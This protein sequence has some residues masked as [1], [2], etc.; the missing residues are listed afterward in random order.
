MQG[1][2]S[3]MYFRYLPFSNQ[4]QC[5]YVLDVVAII[6]EDE[7]MAKRAEINAELET[8]GPRDELR[9]SG[10]ALRIALPASFTSDSAQRERLFQTTPR[11]SCSMTEDHIQWFFELFPN[12]YLS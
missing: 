10:Q 4:R 8:E 9:S 7:W 3:Q 5:K 6:P 11:S 1:P 2:N 12:W